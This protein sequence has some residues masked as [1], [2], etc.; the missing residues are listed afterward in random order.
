MAE[1]SRTPDEMLEDARRR[2]DV[3]AQYRKIKRAIDPALGAATSKATELSMVEEILFAVLYTAKREGI[4]YQKAFD[5]MR[6]L[7]ETR[8]PEAR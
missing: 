5:D 2:T 3:L 8:Y 4:D 6:T 1:D 7:V